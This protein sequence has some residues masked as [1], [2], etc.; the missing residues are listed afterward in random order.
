MILAVNKIDHPK[1]ELAD[2]EFSVLGF[3]DIVPISAAHSRGIGD[4]VEHIERHLPEPTLERGKA[5]PRSL[6]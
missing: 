6:D 4:L 5:E 1:Q 2:A 3:P